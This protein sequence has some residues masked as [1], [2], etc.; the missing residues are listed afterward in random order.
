MRFDPAKEERHLNKKEPRK[1]SDKTNQVP[2]TRINELGRQDKDW[3]C[4]KDCQ[5]LSK[6]AVNAHSIVKS[7]KK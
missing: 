1:M 7:T 2:A 4:G 5:N 3:G 6:W